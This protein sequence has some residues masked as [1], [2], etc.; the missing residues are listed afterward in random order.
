M[1]SAQVFGRLAH[2]P[3][4]VIERCIDCCLNLWAVKG[5]ESKNSAPTH[6]WFVA[7][8]RQYRGQPAGVANCTK[9]GRG[10]F[11]NQC[12]VMLGG[13]VDQALQYGIGDGFVFTCAPRRHLHNGGVIIVEQTGE[14]V[15]TGVVGELCGGFSHSATH[16]HIGIVGHTGEHLWCGTVNADHRTKGDLAHTGVWIVERFCGGG[17]IAAMS[18]NDNV[19]A[20][21]SSAT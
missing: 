11:T 7:A 1:S 3:V 12:V 5:G 13:Q 8:G 21:I 10:R 16:F 14:D 18:G 6:G 9:G 19:V 17:A 20:A 4:S 15:D 2:L